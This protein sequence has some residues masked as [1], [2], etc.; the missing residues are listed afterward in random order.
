MRDNFPVIWGLMKGIGL[1]GVALVGTLLV[2]SFLQSRAVMKNTT[3]GIA[4][5]S[6]LA[7][8]K[9]P[10]PGSSGSLFK[11]GREVFTPDVVAGR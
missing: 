1:L 10:A 2:G 3:A 9:S 4:D 6:F 7:Q 5:R 11:L 8:E